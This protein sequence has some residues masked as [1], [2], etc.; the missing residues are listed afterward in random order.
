MFYWLIIIL[1]LVFIEAMTAN[2]TTIWFVAS[3]FV[4]LILSFF[5]SSFEIQFGV[6]VVGGIILLITTRP[7][8]SKKLKVKSSKTNLD[9]VVGMKGIVTVDI[10]KFNPGEVKVDGKAWTAISDTELKK[11]TVVE[12]LKIEGV[13]LKVKES[14]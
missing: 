3:G 6:F 12:V 1:F 10:T 9:R 7:Y 2:L 5:I 13:K 8:L 14:E 11:D 4:T